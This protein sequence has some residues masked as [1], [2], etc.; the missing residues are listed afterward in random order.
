MQILE[1]C[2]VLWPLQQAFCVSVQLAATVELVHGLG[3]CP[4]STLHLTVL[5]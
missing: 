1:I 2:Y 5:F 3:S 4:K